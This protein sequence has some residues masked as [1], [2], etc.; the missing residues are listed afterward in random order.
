[1]GVG[2]ILWALVCGHDLSDVKRCFTEFPNGVS[3]V[4][5]TGGGRQVMTGYQ[6]AR[7]IQHDRGRSFGSGIWSLIE[8]MR[9]GVCSTDSRYL[10]V[11]VK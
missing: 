8:E 1:M 7:E 2:D 6:A 3:K 4:R 10:Y 5:L 11:P 9:T